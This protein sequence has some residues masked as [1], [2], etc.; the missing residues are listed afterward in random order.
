MKRSVSTLYW[1]VLTTVGLGGG[2]VAGLIVGM[3][4]G[5][6]VNAMIATAAVTCLVGGVLGCAQAFGLRTMLQRPFWWILGTIVGL[7]LGLALGVV[8][9]EQLGILI[10]GI[11]PNVARL[12]P[13]SRAVSFIALGA[14]AGCLLGVAQWLV[15]RSQAPRIRGWVVTSTTGL[16]LSFCASSVLLDL[17]RV[18]IGSAF[19]AI[20]FVVTSS[21]LFGAITSQPFQH[22]A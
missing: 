22:A 15:L 7:G 13:I 17:A 11:R 19:G 20:A 6:L 16:A 2:L 21:L 14:V 9:V 3:P 12:D 10:T 18:P 8:I 5:E 1:T 4:I